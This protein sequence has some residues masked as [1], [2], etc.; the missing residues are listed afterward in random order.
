MFPNKLT[1]LV[2]N[3]I[4]KLQYDQYLS[5]Y[6]GKTI[7]YFGHESRKSNGHKNKKTK[8]IDATAITIKILGITLQSDLE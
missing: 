6:I 1:D 2:S 7:A 8:D 5:R 4:Y 3:S